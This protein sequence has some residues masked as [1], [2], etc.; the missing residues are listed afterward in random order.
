MS[1]AYVL[2]APIP[3]A[4][5]VKIFDNLLGRPIVFPSSNESL[6]PVPFS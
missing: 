4:I 3:R 5:F 2:G 6:E 1:Q